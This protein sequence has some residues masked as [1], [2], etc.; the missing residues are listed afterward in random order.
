MYIQV[1]T[2]TP[3]KKNAEEIAG[4]VVNRALGA[5]AQVLGPIESRYVWK[6]KYTVQKEWVCLIKTKRSSYKKLEEAI[7]KMHK[8]EVPEIIAVKIEEGN[9]EYFKWVD[10]SLR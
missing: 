10:D 6:G 3:T 2:T 4:F 7:R 1:T 8:Y 5:C 9:R